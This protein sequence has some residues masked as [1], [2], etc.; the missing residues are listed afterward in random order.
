MLD[1]SRSRTGP[2]VAALV[3]CL[4][5]DEAAVAA[6]QDCDTLIRVE[7]ADTRLATEICEAARSTL[8]VAGTCGLV[9]TEPVTIR[10]AAQV[11]HGLDACLSHYDCSRSEITL[12]TPSELDAAIGPG[13][14]YRVLPSAV[15]LKNLV[16]HEL[17]HALADQSSGEVM[18]AGVDQEYIAAA[19]ELEAMDPDWR[20]ALLIASAKS[21]EPRPG[22]ISAGIYALAPRAFAANAWLHFHQPGEGCAT[23]MRLLKGSQSFAR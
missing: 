19:F 6:G 20:E 23:I 16:S 4:A 13:D 1:K 12:T 14:A 2:T 21:R 22:L 17:A 7:T 11:V 5:A 15:V 10:V 9:Q 18:L 8:S 3:L